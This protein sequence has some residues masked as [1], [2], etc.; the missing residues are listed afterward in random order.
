MMTAAL[1]LGVHDAQT[2]TLVLYLLYCGHSWMVKNRRTGNTTSNHMEQPGGGTRRNT[3]E[4][5]E[6]HTLVT[7]L[8]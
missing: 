7:L 3:L 4:R 8:F 6:R 2:D 5:A 1:A